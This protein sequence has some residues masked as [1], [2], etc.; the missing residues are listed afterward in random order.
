MTPRRRSAAYD[1]YL[2]SGPRRRKTMVHVLDLLGCV[3]TGPTTDDALAATPDAIRAYLRFLARHGERVDPAAPVETRVAEHVTEGD[4]LGNGSPYLVFAPDFEPVSA[5]EAKRLLERFRWM[6]EDLAAWAETQSDRRLD[7]AARGE[8]GRTARAILL[9]VIG[10]TGSYLSASLGGV[11][12][13]SH[14]A[15][16][17]ERGEMPLGEALRTVAAMAADAV[18]AATPEQR[19]AVIERPKDTRTLRK[20]I[21]RMLE[22]CW[23]HTAELS[24]RPGGPRL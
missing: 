11:K 3:A 19:T 18:A 21:R 7:A 23:E 1:V 13:F 4:W 12:G 9:H 2:E 10:P 14:V 16:M 6:S 17:A 20:S 15:G 5:A 22:H 8:R 24:R